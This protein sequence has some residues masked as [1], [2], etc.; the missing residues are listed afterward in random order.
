M[1]KPGQSG[2][3][4]GRPK[5]ILG[6]IVKKKTKDGV[7]LVDRVLEIFRSSGDD[8]IVIKAATWL[9]DRGW[10]KPAQS[11]EVGGKDGGDIIVKIVL[12]GSGQ[13]WQKK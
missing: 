6:P 10:G 12:Q 9:A 8:E 13:P 11:V 5:D 2:N 4:S 3:P 1:F 7:E